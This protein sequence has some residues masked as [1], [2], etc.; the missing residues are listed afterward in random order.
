MKM[1][2]SVHVFNSTFHRPSRKVEKMYPTSK[3][4]SLWVIL[5]QVQRSI[6]REMELALKAE[7]LPP[8]R[9]YDV[10]WAIERVKDGGLRPVEME[11]SLIF[12]QSNL[13]RLLQR[14]VAEGLVKE[15]VFQDDRRGKL[16]SITAKGHQVR[17]RMWKIYGPL[18]H[19]H[20]CVLSIE[21]DP[22]DIA[23]ALS[24]LI[25]QHR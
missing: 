21:Y 17:M 11:K 5:N 2:V 16:L 22:E 3:E 10:L 7:G 1:H 14:M 20:M 18:I 8:L 19:Q 4:T 6:H 24:S 12:E 13:S 25:T 23:L 15:S 9:W